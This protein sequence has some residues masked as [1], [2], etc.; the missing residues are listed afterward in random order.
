MTSQAK[1]DP[2]FTVVVNHEEQYS[3]W[4]A[5]REIPPGWSSVGPPRTRE[6]C[7]DYIEEVWTDMRPL[8]LRQ[9][10]DQD[11]GAPAPIP[12]AT[13]DTDDGPVMRLVQGTHPVRVVLGEQP[14][15]D[16]LRHAVQIGY[17]HIEFPDTRGGT[18]LGVRLTPEE[19][20][21]R[22]CDA[23]NPA[24]RVRLAGRLTLDDVNVR[25][26]ADIDLTTFEGSGR[27]EVES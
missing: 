15:I 24:G 6:E 25:C 11:A 10:M 26:L 27:L 5:D 19:C 18:T 2:S 22:N 7:L 1:P 17:V 23:A 4:P 3:V 16:E 21:L 20:D 9:A 14:T 12:N 8:S 13:A